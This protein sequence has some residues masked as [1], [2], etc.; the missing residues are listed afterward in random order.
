MFAGEYVL[1]HGSLSIAT[2]MEVD[3][4]ATTDLSAALST[5]TMAM[6]TLVT[7][8]TLREGSTIRPANAAF[9]YCHPTAIVLY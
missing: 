7:T 4:K 8:K 3:K 5:T 9:S 2:A 1:L 6:K